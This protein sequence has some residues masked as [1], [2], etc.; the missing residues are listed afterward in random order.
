MTAGTGIVWIILAAVAVILIMAAVIEIY[1]ELHYFVVTHY[2]I[3]PE[4][5]SGTGSS[6]RI[7]FLSDLHNKVY[8][9]KN[10]VL[11]R[12]VK[13]EK[14]DMILIGGDM[15]VGKEDVSYR[16]ALEFVRK[17][18]D[19]CPVFYANGNHEQRM[20]EEPEQYKY[21]Y[22]KYKESLKRYGVRFLENE[23]ASVR[24]KGIN[25][26]V[27][28]LELPLDSYRKFSKSS[29]TSTDL[30]RQL[31]FEP[32]ASKQS[33]YSSYHILLAHNPSYMKA[34]KEWGAD[35][36]LSGHLH[37]GMVRLPGI[38]GV[39]TPQAFLFPRYSGEM[40]EE[41][42]QT[43]IVSRGLG[44]HTINLRL[45]NSAEVVSLKLGE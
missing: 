26:V 12:A 22:K 34:Y 29:V 20:K 44:T 32:S 11:Y 2:E 35:L 33:I 25:F 1:R 8:G 39:I 45:F 7:V 16:P 31:G 5:L 10:D 36:I 17:L 43:V 15:L 18:P 21:S 3:H 41:G 13:R 9:E 30:T 42:Q 38:G 19:I 37:G 40:R 28:G 6:V 23:S 27:S 14:P 4:K 24:M